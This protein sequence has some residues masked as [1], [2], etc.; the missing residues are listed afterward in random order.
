MCIRDRSADESDLM[1]QASIDG[2]S[3]YN[4]PLAQTGYRAYHDEADTSAFVSYMNT[5]DS[6]YDTS[7]GVYT[8]ML[9]ILVMI[10]SLVRVVSFIC[11]IQLQLHSGRIFGVL[12]KVCTLVMHLQELEQVDIMLPLQL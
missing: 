4:V 1:W 9:I 8:R 5:V 2:G 7:P 10:Q 12:L 3:N 6:N 11:I